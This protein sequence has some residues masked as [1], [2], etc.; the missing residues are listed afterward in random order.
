[1]EEVLEVSKT[2]KLTGA[3]NWTS[4]KFETRVKL[5]AIGAMG[6]VTGTNP[7]PVQPQEEGAQ[8]EYRN[9]LV[10]WEISEGKAQSVIVCSLTHQVQQHVRSCATAKEM[11]DRLHSIFESKSETTAHMLAQ[12]WY[13]AKKD[14]SESMATYISKIQ[15]LAHKM[16]E[17]GE[18]VSDV[19]VIR[20]ILLTL[21]PHL[22]HFYTSWEGTSPES[23]TLENLTSRLLMEEERKG[24]RQDDEASEALVAR[25]FHKHTGKPGSNKTGPEVVCNYCK[26]PGHVWKICFK[27]KREQGDKTKASQR[28]ADGSVGAA[29]IQ[30]LLLATSLPK[31][32][33]DKWLLDSGAS[34]HMSGRRE[35]FTNLVTK[36]KS[37]IRVG[38]GKVLET[39]LYGTINIT[40]FNGK[41]W[42]KMHLDNVLFIPELKYNLFSMSSAAD[43]GYVATMTNS[44]CVISKNGNTAAV[45]EREKNLYTMKFKVL[46]PSTKGIKHALVAENDK[47]NLKQWHER[48]AH[49]NYDHVKRLLDTKGIK[50]VGE[51][52]ECQ[53]CV[54]GKMSR[55][56]H[57]PSRSTTTRVGQLV[58]ADVCGKMPV[59]SLNGSEYFLLF[60]DDFSNYRYVY[61]LKQKSDVTAC[62]INFLI[63][64]KKETGE[65]IDTLRTDN[66]KEFVNKQMNKLMFDNGIK[67]QKTVP[68][69]PEQNGKVERDNRT[70]VEAARTMLCSKQLPIKLWAEAVNTAVYVI[71]RTGKSSVENKT[72][73]ELWYKTTV[74][75]NHFK[76]FGTK[77]LVHVPKEHRKKWDLKAEE[78]VMVGYS[79]E[80]KG[81]RI[82]FPQHNKIEARCDIKFL[83]DNQ[84]ENMTTKLSNEEMSALQSWGIKLSTYEEDQQTEVPDDASDDIISVDDASTSDDVISVNDASTSAD[85]YNSVDSRTV[86]STDGNRC[87]AIVCLHPKERLTTWICCDLCD[88]WYHMVCVGADAGTAAGQYVCIMCEDNHNAPAVALVS[89]EPENYDSAKASDNKGEWQQAMSEEM[90]AHKVNGTWILTE[91]PA[92]ANV[93]K[94]R[95]VFKLKQK[96]DGSVERYKARLVVKG[97]QQKAGFDYAE[98]FSPVVKF[99][100]IR[101]MLSLAASRNMQIKQFDIKTAFLYGEIQEDVYME[102]PEGFCDGSSKVCKLKKSLYGLKQAPRCWN[103]KLVSCLEKFNMKPV[104]ADPCVFRSSG[105]IDECIIVAI[106]VD[107]GL[108]IS[109][110]SRK[111]EVLLEQLKQNFDVKVSRLSM[112]LGIQLN[113]TTDGS[114]VA[115]QTLYTRK[116]LEK[117]NMELAHPVSIPADNYQNVSMLKTT[118]KDET[119][120]NVPFREAVG[121]LLFLSMVTRPDIAF[122]VNAVSQHCNN[123][124]R[125]HWEAVKR[126]IKYLKGTLDFGIKFESGKGTRLVGF[127]DADFAGESIT[128]KSTSGW[129]LKLNDCPIIW[130]SRKQ[131]AIALSTAEAEFVA[132]CQ[133]SINLIWVKSLISQLI[134]E[135]IETPVLFIDNQS[136]ITWIKNGQFETKSKHVDIKFK[137]VFDGVKQSKFIPEYV[138]TEKQLADIF[139]K[140]LP[141]KR[142][143][144][145]RKMIG[146]I[147]CAELN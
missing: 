69:T 134:K 62:F 109:R 144:K 147:D 105:N 115:R 130:G 78:G 145:L 21:P 41:T 82:W 12:R 88:N 112:F 65:D 26:K 75:M 98:T 146:I 127:A 97:C 121:S 132:A 120:L 32:L 27:R 1:M 94:N 68:Y 79:Q 104:D 92:K 111:I 113:R 36:E 138:N 124:Q 51:R 50:V 85:D 91:R 46:K 110:D 25:K 5:M 140:P 64:I 47:C 131:K 106:Y 83:Q 22:D 66:G 70:F 122:A 89:D 17:M 73:C 59:P 42:V 52:E 8:Q 143:E 95:W 15:D 49:Q 19:M 39:N 14:D 141:T 20:K 77:V 128:R 102:Q 133:T 107:D 60:K 93:L 136:A 99:D 4:W 63:R 23:R 3:E 119:L 142:F 10:K 76:E 84:E 54:F 7:I 53:P 30:E 44:K 117:F 43:K 72:P 129:L 29:L 18:P 40:G 108:V 16:K 80:V 33:S 24:I 86:D 81:Y 38:D 28:T 2:S 35:W 96:P 71:N 45:G 100:S 31:G 6:I 11:W 55:I 34:Y 74:D 118:K 101:V 126:I 87:R 58:H 137:F 103:L 37:L 123:Y 90:Q 9:S 13:A 57:P 56:P 67:H 135:K 61:F 116:I 48:L 125:P 114:I 139:T